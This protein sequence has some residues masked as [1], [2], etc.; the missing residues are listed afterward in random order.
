M[1]VGLTL[2]SSALA[3][4]PDFAGTVKDGAKAEKPEAH[5]T[6]E[7]GGALTT[8]N[9][10]FFTLSAGLNAS[11]RWQK[12]KVGIIGGAV[13]GSSRVDANA[14]GTLSEAERSV[15]MQPNAKR[16]FA[17]G[18][19]DLFLSGR[20]SLY[21]LAGAFHD[22]FSGYDSRTHEQVGYSRMLVKNDKTKV[23]AEVGIDFAQE[24]YIAEKDPNYQSVLAARGMFG[25]VHKFSD[26]VGIEDTTELYENVLDFED[27]RILNTA[28]IVS[29]LNS[30]LSLKLSHNL[31]FDN[32]PVEGFRTTDQSMQVTLV[33]SIL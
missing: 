25:F 6:A 8:G 13:A 9:S 31:I 21:V 3:A 22:P 33:A 30:K 23:V 19:Y 2:V 32:Q 14:D 4:D 28:S 16:V 7:A 5:L 29:S 15:P 17:D 18:R 11:Y 12:S 24:N 26:H 20:D 10:E 27:L 1:L